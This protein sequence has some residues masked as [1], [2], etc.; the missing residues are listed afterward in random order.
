MV[1]L[2]NIQIKIFKDQYIANEWLK[3]NKETLIHKISYES[4]S[5]GETASGYNIMV[6]HDAGQ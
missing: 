6:I 5:I 4:Y 1:Q 3:K 2:R